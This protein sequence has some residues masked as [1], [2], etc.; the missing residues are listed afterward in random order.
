MIPEYRIHGS[1][2]EVL[3]HQLGDHLLGLRLVYLVLRPDV[4]VLTVSSPDDHVGCDGRVDLDQT[5]F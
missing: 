2:G 4:V 5:L 3:L 1:V